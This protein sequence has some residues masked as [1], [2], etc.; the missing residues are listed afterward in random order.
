MPAT[1]P[2]TLAETLLSLLMVVVVGVGVYG[3]GRRRENRECA[4][5]WMTRAQ[6]FPATIAISHCGG[7][8][9]SDLVS[10]FTS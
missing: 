9:E 2:A 10:T 1:V 7:V 6:T 5:G 4:V 3:G 8:A